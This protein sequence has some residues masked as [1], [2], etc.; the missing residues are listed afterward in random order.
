MRETDYAH[1]GPY[2][3][4]GLKWPTIILQSSRAPKSKPFGF[5]TIDNRWVIWVSLSDNDQNPNVFVPISDKNEGLKA[6]LM[7][8]TECFTFGSK[9]KNLNQTFLEPNVWKLNVWNPKPKK[10]RFRCSTVLQTLNL[11]FK[12]Q[13]RIEFMKLLKH[14]DCK[15]AP[16]HLSTRQ[17]PL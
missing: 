4:F 12:F 11:E 8:Q 10:F 2:Q 14:L 5:Q 9:H 7:V 1:F 17:F 6:K 13:T 16:N 15:S 3:L